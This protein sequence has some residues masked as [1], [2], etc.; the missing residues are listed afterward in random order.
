MSGILA[1]VKKYGQKSI[2]SLKMFDLRKKKPKYESA[3]LFPDLNE[4]AE[5]GEIKG[6]SIL[7]SLISAFI[8]NSNFTV[9]KRL[10]EIIIRCFS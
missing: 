8:F 9:E 10:L 6:M 7:P 4:L 5:E 1:Q 3:E 2:N